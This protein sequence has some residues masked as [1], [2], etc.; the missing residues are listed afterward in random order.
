MN[1]LP[2]ALCAQIS[3]LLGARFSRAVALRESHAGGGM[4]LRALPP[5]AVDVIWSRAKRAGAH[6]VA[7]GADDTPDRDLTLRRLIAD[8]FDVKP[9]DTGEIDGQAFGVVRVR[10][11]NGIVHAEA[12]LIT[13]QLWP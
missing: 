13:G 12:R 11:D 7:A 9:G 8:G 1:D 10:R 4:H 3:T 6:H 2:S 5:Q